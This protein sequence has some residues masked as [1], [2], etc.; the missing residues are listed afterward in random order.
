MCQK[1]ERSRGTKRKGRVCGQRTFCVDWEVDFY[2]FTV[3][4]KDCLEVC[5]DDVAREMADDDDL[6]VWLSV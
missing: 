5:L 1:R 6:G 3:E 2:D 4:G